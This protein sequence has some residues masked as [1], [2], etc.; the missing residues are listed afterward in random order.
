MTTCL[1]NEPWIGPCGKPVAEGHWV[2]QKHSEEKCQVCG[3]QATTRCQASR[4]VMCGIPLCS[5][6]GAGEMCLYH[7]GGGPLLAIR[8][9]LGGG[10]EP[11]V[12]AARDMLIKDA[13]NMVEIAR[14][15]RAMTLKPTM[16]DF[17]AAAAKWAK[18]P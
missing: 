4:G 1:F 6:C 11:T 15:L 18:E 16:A 17:D 9:L 2:C 12:F 10:P 3:Q 14:R 7:A 13:A 5:L 8:A